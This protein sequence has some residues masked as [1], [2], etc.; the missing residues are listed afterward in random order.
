MS[1]APKP[2][3]APPEAAKPAAPAAAAAAASPAAAPKPAPAAAKPVLPPA[4]AARIETR[5][6]LI[7][8]SFL[9][10]VALP[11]SALAVYLWG[12]A[13]DQYASHLGFSVRSETAIQP[14]E[15]LGGLTGK[16]NSSSSDPDILYKFINSRAMV[17]AVDKELDLRRIWGQAD[18]SD[19]L[20]AYRGGKSIE[21]LL[22]HWSRK[23]L[24]YYDSGMLDVR[25]LAYDPKDAQNIAQAVFDNSSNMIN[26][27]NDIAREDTIRYSREELEKSVERLKV[28]RQAMTEFRDRHQLVD[29]TAD[30]QGQLGILT[31]LQQQLAEAVIGLGMLQSN[32]R[33]DDPRI[34]Q[35]KLRIKVIE[36]QIQQERQKFGGATQEGEVLSSVVGEFERLAV[37][38]QFAET[39]YTAALASFDNAQSEAQRKSRYLA[40]YVKPTLAETAEFPERLKI[41]ATFSF[42]IVLLWSIGVLVYY[43]IRNRR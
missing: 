12:F 21:D 18:G 39:T 15:I 26:Q 33:G 13:R 10:L 3:T 11:I 14:L 29:P 42:F 34:D 1:S 16:A 9:L 38:R 32:S 20:F 23:V 2:Q 36:D 28:A 41:L 22:D 43:S 7:G 4:R 31:S 8:L 27:L 35:Q 6:K 37:D 40:A 25:V 5:H 19:P 17:E 30:V 24:V